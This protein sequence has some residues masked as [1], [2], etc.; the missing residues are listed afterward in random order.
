MP[1]GRISQTQA[2]NADKLEVAE[3]YLAFHRCKLCKRLTIAG[4]I[5]YWCKGDDS[6]R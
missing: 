1:E 4:Y 5:C 2:D 6:D 3:Q